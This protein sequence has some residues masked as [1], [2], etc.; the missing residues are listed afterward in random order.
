[1]YIQNKP[2]KGNVTGIQVAQTFIFQMHI[3]S[4]QRD[5]SCSFP[6]VSTDLKLRGIKYNSIPRSLIFNK[7]QNFFT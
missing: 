2:N 1:M 6:T 5:K 7:N 4:M 3:S